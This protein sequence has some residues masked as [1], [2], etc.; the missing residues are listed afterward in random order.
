MS[1]CS[2]CTNRLISSI[3]SQLVIPPLARPLSCQSFV[4]RSPPLLHRL[5]SRRLFQDSARRLV[6]PPIASKPR[7]E[8]PVSD[9]TTQTDFNEMNVLGNVPPPASAIESCRE[10]GF[11]LANGVNIL[12]SGIMLVAGEVFRWSPWN[13]KTDTKQDTMKGL[14]R[15]NGTVH[16][17]PEVWG[18]LDVIWP[19]PDLLVIGTG[20]SIRAISPET[21]KIINNMGIRLEVLDTRNAAAQYNLLAT[22]RGVHEVAAAMI[23]IEMQ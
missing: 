9:E 18:I 23:P 19:K 14:L 17:G 1:F 11:V 8:R 4:Q 6:K 3:R 22:E 16:F 2:S 12:K 10:D 21:R 15:L 13:G 7:E 20:K 5:P